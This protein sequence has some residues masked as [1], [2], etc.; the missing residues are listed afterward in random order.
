[1]ASTNSNSYVWSVNLHISS[2]VIHQ[3]CKYTQL[4]SQQSRKLRGSCFG[5]C[6]GANVC[7]GKHTHSA[8]DPQ[9]TSVKTHLGL[10]LIGC[11]T[12]TINAHGCLVTLW[13]TKPDP[14]F[15][16]WIGAN[17]GFEHLDLGGGKGETTSTPPSWDNHLYRGKLK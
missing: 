14:P 17:W 1:M 3:A 7:E 16:L 8:G 6:S 13:A 11:P 10:H 5:R 9:K 4:P 2:F 12:V 15:V